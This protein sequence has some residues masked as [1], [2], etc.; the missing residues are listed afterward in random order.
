MYEA[1]PM[2]FII[3]Q[4][5]GAATNGRERILDIQPQALHQRV[6]VVLGSKD[7][8]DRVARYHAGN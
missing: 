7:E 4:A 5:G 1:N 8:V 2:S 6:G 3:E